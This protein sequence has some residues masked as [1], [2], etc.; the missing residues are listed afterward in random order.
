MKKILGFLLVSL[1][2]TACETTE[3]PDGYVVNGTAKGVINGIRV[4]LKTKDNRGKELVKDTAIVID[5]KFKFEGKVNRP[6]VWFLHVNSVNG[7]RP[8]MIENDYI[9]VEIE[10]DSIHA[11]KVT[12]TK[13]N[14]VF[15]I[16]SNTVKELSNE[17]RKLNMEFK[18]ADQTSD[19][20]KAKELQAKIVKNNHD[21]ANLP[22]ELISE[23]NDN[24]FVLILIESLIS[25]NN[26]D[27]NKLIESY[28]TLSSDIKGSDFGKTIQN[29][30]EALK[31]EKERLANLEIGKAAPEFSAPD[32]DGKM[33]ALK[34]MRGKVTIIDFWASW[35]GPC[36]REN[37][38]V[39]KVYEKYHDK[40]LEI[41][42]VSLDKQGQK[43]RWL[44]AIEKDN[45]TWHHVSNLAYFNDPVAKQYA[46][47]SIPATYIL[48]EE[49]TIIAKNLRG[50]ALENKI[51]ELLD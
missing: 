33:L 34:D 19:T 4:Y 40:G 51:A 25:S 11:T 16:Y 44:S 26:A 45:L 31:K 49:G 2:L 20:E 28:N 21:M 48:D 9:D 41:I 7:N 6:Q 3:K 29:K 46:I 1:L 50:P 10:K 17:R 8:F 32:P 24:N 23:H 42:G 18:I 47:N 27:L 12:G 38:N 30:I 37:P 39:V 35:C 13:S 36:R 15:N 5:E 22:F 43:D 14:E